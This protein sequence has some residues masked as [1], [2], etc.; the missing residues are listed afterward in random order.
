MTTVATMLA[1]A[2][3]LLTYYNGDE[4][5]AQNPGGLTGV[6][7]MADN[8]DPCIQD[9][10]T[11][12]TGVGDALSAASSSEGNAAAS[13]SAAAGSATAANA[14]KLAAPTSEGNAAG[15]AT[16]AANSASAAAGSATAANASKLAAATSEG[17]A[18]ASATMTTQQAGIATTKAGEAAGSATT[19]TQQAGIATTKAGEAAGSATTATQK[20]QIATDKAAEAAASAAA[21]QTWN[22]ANYVAKR[23]MSSFAYE[24]GVDLNSL[25]QVYE[26]K[27]VN[28][29]SLVNGPGPN[30]GSLGYYLGLAG[31]DSGAV[32]GLQMVYGVDTGRMFFRDKYMGGW[33]EFWHTGNLPVT[34]S[35]TSMNFTSA[36]T[37]NVI[38]LANVSNT[39]TPNCAAGNEFDCQII[40]AASTIA[41]PLNPPGLGKAQQISIKW[42]QDGTGGRV[43][44][45]GGNCVNVGGTTANT[46][47]GKVNYAVGK[48]YSDGKF[49]YSVVRGS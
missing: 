12:G 48:V 11:V 45:F 15:F 14:S 21:A 16:A 47:A 46:A 42:T 43:M 20:A 29:S 2:Q 9:I 19:A 33:R 31:G 38:A 17:N 25:N 28:P 18:A 24:T 7:G 34:V 44:S 35:G 41:N 8:W 26:T 10:G 13:A 36:L 5:T 6:G 49:Y 1:A 22:P 23:S 32:L 37:V 39:F 3:R 30:I 4:K 27:Y 40:G